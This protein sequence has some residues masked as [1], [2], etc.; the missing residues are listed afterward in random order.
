[1]KKALLMIIAGTLASLAAAQDLDLAVENIPANLLEQANAV[2][3]YSYTQVAIN[4]PSDMTYRVKKAITV[5]NRE[6]EDYGLAYV[7]YDPSRKIKEIKAGIYDASGK[8]AAMVREKDFTDQ[9]AVS[10]I[11]I[12]EDTRVKYYRPAVRE[13]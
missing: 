12:Y 3:R 1:M 8:L 13:Y 7:Y 4:S 11:S 9:S 6:G 10:D 2:T 5:L